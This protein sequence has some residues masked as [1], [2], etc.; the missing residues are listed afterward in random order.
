MLQARCI[1]WFLILSLHSSHYHN[2]PSITTNYHTFIANFS[3]ISF[4]CC[5]T[6]WRRIWY[7]RWHHRCVSFFYLFTYVRYHRWYHVWYHRWYHFVISQVIS[8]GD[9]TCDITC[10]WASS[11]CLWRCCALF[12]YSFFNLLIQP[13]IFSNP[14]VKPIEI[15]T[16][17]LLNR[18]I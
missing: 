6:F 10:V 8:I 7:N 3:C 1:L 4:S 15:R 18:Q 13:Y 9:I 14:V 16:M 12:N 5:S 2:N 17:Y 11:V